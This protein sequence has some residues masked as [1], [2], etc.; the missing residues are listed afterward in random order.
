MIVSL[1][2]ALVIVSS[3]IISLG[4]LYDI[5]IKNG[6]SDSKTYTVSTNN[7]SST[8]NM[9]W[10]SLL[11]S[12]V[13][14]TS[15]YSQIIQNNYNLIK[16]QD[17][18]FRAVNHGGINEI[19]PKWNIGGGLF[20]KKDTE[21]YTNTPSVNA[22][23]GLFGSFNYIHYYKQNLQYHPSYINKIGSFYHSELLNPRYHYFWRGYLN[24]TSYNLNNFSYHNY[25]S[26]TTFQSSSDLNLTPSFI[27]P[28][29]FS[30]SQKAGIVQSQSKM[31]IN[32]I[33][34][35]FLNIWYF[36]NW[37]KQY[38]IYFTS[39]QYYDL[40]LYGKLL[41]DIDNDITHYGWL[42]DLY[43][44]VSIRYNYIVNK[45]IVQNY[46]IPE[47]A[48]T[49]TNIAGGLLDASLAS[50]EASIPP[51]GW[52]LG[53]IVDLLLNGLQG[54]HVKPVEKTQ[55]INYYSNFWTYSRMA[56]IFDNLLGTPAE[57][58]KGD[59]SKPIANFY[60][61]YNNFP[62]QIHLQNFNIFLY[63]KNFFERFK[64]NFMHYTA[65]KTQDRPLMWQHY[66]Q[67]LNYIFNPKSLYPYLQLKILLSKPLGDIQKLFDLI[68]KS[69]NSG[70][71][72]PSFWTNSDASKIPNEI[73]QQLIGGIPGLDDLEN[74]ANQIT[75]KGTLP[76]SDGAGI[77]TIQIIYN[78]D[79]FANI[80]TI[81]L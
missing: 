57:L 62:A 15:N 60:H 69:Y 74:Y 53:A 59:Y 48:G 36:E 31:F 18:S 28:D 77:K 65:A 25:S 16:G 8:Q 71:V 75:F 13:T 12:N 58:R 30:Y 63:L 61:T 43:F 11:N 9:G 81:Y 4:D 17:Y 73:L 34:N 6:E 52:M 50:S 64:S 45:E 14:S 55:S 29:D 42:Q 66:L 51:L 68:T 5:N 46:N 56:L 19:R 22:K 2:S 54:T 21:T 44:N 1:C 10:N 78:H 40:S 3:P 67:K 49:V 70:F 47:W 27:G 38:Y 23:N 32:Q 7:L 33:L 72:L 39:D 20:L 24:K 37:A 41:N 35:D 79:I 76:T 26:T 80:K